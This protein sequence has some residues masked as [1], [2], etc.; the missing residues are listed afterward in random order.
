VR[1]DRDSEAPAGAVV[2][3]RAAKARERRPEERLAEALAD[4]PWKGRNPGESPVAAVLNPQAVGGNAHQ[5]QSPETVT[6][7]TGPLLSGIGSNGMVKRYVGSFRRRR[8]D[9]WLAP[10]S[11]G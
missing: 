7:R 5:G 8:L 9:T 10:N 11:E 2:R 1:A 6:C 3:D 4:Q